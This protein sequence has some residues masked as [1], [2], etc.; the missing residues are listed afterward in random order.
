MTLQT[1]EHRIPDELVDRLR[2]AHAVTAELL[3]DVIRETCSRFLSIRQAENTARIE[4]LTKSGA[5]TDAVL[6]LIELE[7]PQW[8]LRRVVYDAG[9]W[10]CALSRQR[11]LPDWLDQSIEASHTELPLALLIALVEVRRVSGSPVSTSV[12][13]APRATEAFYTPLCCDNFA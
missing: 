1:A 4:R 13:K 6:A 7:L 9:E 5:W 3:D 12:P 11:E 2:D 8:Q 10:C